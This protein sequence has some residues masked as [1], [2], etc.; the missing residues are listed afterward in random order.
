MWRWSSC[1]SKSF[2]PKWNKHDVLNSFLFIYDLLTSGNNLRCFIMTTHKTEQLKIKT[3]KVEKEIRSYLEEG[4]Q[5]S[6]Q[7][8]W[9]LHLSLSCPE[10]KKKTL[11]QKVSLWT[12]LKAFVPGGIWKKNKIES[13]RIKKKNR[14]RNNQT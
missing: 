9:G 13:P 5:L 10:V 6:N 8:V 12:S 7:L 4:T 2:L 3:F 1:A 11:I 14:Y